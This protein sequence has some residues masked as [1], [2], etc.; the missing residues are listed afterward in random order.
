MKTFSKILMAFAIASLPFACTK[1]EKNEPKGAKMVPVELSLGIEGAQGDLTRAA[2]AL[3]PEVE[4]WVFDYY[5]VQYTSRGI[6]V[7]S[8]HRRADVTVGDMVVKDQIWLWDVGECTVVYIANIR[9]AGANYGD[10]PAWE[11]E[12]G[13]TVL[14]ADNLAAFKAMKFDMTKRI[15]A[16]EDNTLKHM[17]MC[18]YWEGSITEANNTEADPFH[19]TTTLGRMIVRMNLSIT[20]NSG[21]AITKVKLNNAASKAYLYPQVE[22]APL[23][24]ADYMDIENTISI[25][26]GKHQALTFYTAPNFCEAGGNV[27]SLT[28][29]NAN[30]VE[31]TL[32]LGNDVRKQDYNLYM[33]TIYSFNINLK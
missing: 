1:T 8:G 14:I 18:G 12:G 26:N 28:F 13:G 20:N 3:F 2:S 10:A 15:E 27:T 16:I 25:P 6:S 23:D 11:S 32:E 22:N 21:A 29:T 33:N 19:M 5:Y 24:D 7:T 4:N 17:P 30:G 31:K 9:P